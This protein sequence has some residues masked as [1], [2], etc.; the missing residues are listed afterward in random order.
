MNDP[1][2][3]ALTSVRFILDSIDDA[4]TGATEVTEL[5]HA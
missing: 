4:R 3:L 5:L 1:S 2:H